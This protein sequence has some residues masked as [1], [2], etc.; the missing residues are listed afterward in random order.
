M[1]EKTRSRRACVPVVV[2]VVSGEHESGKYAYIQEIGRKE[3]ER[4][5]GGWNG[6]TAWEKMKPRST[7]EMTPAR[8]QPRVFSS[9]DS[10]CTEQSSIVIFFFLLI[11]VLVSRYDDTPEKKKEKKG[12]SIVDSRARALSLVSNKYEYIHTHTRAQKF[13]QAYLLYR[14]IIRIRRITFPSILFNS[15][16]MLIYRTTLFKKM[17]SRNTLLFI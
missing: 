14:C 8:R 13:V 4:G 3:Q 15:Q 10:R 11:F 1:V 12:K 16:E 9:Y 5:D 2:E 6:Y 17:I 7:R